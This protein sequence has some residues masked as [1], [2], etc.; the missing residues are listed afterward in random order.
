[1][2]S[3]QLYLR[4]LRYLVPFRGML[5]ISLVAMIIS[6]LA[7]PAFARLIKPLIDGNFVNASNNTD[8]Y[9]IPLAIVGLFLL[10]GAAAF[11]NEY[12]SSWVSQQLIF[13][14]RG[15]MFRHLL[16]LPAGFHD[17]KTSSEVV[18]RIAHEAPRSARIT[19][20]AALPSTAMH[21][22]ARMRCGSE[23]G[24]RRTV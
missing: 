7:E 13:V 24:R 16:S 11:V 4:L 6:G 20:G 22:Q 15:E 14:L 23:S 2:N 1:M 9:T 12:T 3:K 17:Q 21:I 19:S 10:K 8:L 18:S 5:A